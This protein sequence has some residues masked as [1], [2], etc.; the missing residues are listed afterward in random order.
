[1]I[2][3]KHKAIIVHIP[4]TGGTSIENPL[5]MNSSVAR[6]LLSIKGKKIYIESKEEQCNNLRANHETFPGN[7]ESEKKKKN[8]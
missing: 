2:S 5:N 3:H 4:K 8:T 1:M 6:H 7:Q